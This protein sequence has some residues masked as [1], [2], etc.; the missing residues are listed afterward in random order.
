MSAGDGRMSTGDG[1]GS[2]EATERRAADLPLPGGNFQ[3]FIQKLAYQALM[4]L[5]VVEHPAHGAQHVDLDQARSLLED[6]A[7]LADKT[8]GN[9]ED[10]EQSF[11]DG[12]LDQLRQRFQ[13]LR[14]A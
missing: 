9:L 2:P 7:M 10:E 3:L 11:L 1:L 4:N 13:E 12:A 14:Q 5:G 8:R 6:L